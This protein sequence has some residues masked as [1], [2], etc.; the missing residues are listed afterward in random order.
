MRHVFHA[1][2][3]LR[4]LCARAS[5]LFSRASPRQA[6]PGHCALAHNALQLRVR[7]CVSGQAADPSR[8]FMHR[9]R[10]NARL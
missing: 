2:A 8:T 10:D 4:S 7:P 1:C 3:K 6:L 5:R 9:R